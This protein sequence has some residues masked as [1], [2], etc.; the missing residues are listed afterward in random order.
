MAAA[1]LLDACMEGD[2]RRVLLLA[3]TGLA[4]PMRLLESEE[5]FFR[6]TPLHASAALNDHQSLSMILPPISLYRHHRS[7][8]GDGR[9]IQNGRGALCKSYKSMD[10]VVERKNERI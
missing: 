8:E 1:A 9:A 2:R 6:Q 7:H 5:V 4:N 3:N 10:D